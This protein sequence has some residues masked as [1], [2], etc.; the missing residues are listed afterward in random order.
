MSEKVSSFVPVKIGD[1]NYLYLLVTWNDFVTPIRE[2]LEKQIDP[3]GAVLGLAGKVIQAFKSMSSRTFQEVLSKE[4][5]TGTKKRIEQ[6]HDQT[7]HP[8]EL[9]WFSDFSK[10]TDSIYRL[11]AALAR[12]TRE[13]ADVFGYLR[14]LTQRQAAGKWAKLAKYVE[15]KPKVFGISIDVGAILED[16]GKEA[17]TSQ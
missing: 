7:F 17:E 2:E 3:F 12:K 6:D 14:S 4:W 15:L 10:R 5:D 9:I 8:S 1:F 16:I 11:F 13:D